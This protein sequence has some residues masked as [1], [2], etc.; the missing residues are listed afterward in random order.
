M[1]VSLYPEAL[2]TGRYREL[3][4]TNR[5]YAF[6][7]IL[8]NEAVITVLNNDGNEAAFSVPM[9]ERPV[10]MTD[11]MTGEEIPVPEGNLFVTLPAGGCL[12]TLIRW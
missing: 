5:Q 2:R 7:R 6:A 3:L 4:L 11:L 8:G 9:P 1:C 12:L 10:A